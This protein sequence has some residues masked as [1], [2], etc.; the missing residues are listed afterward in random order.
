M[1]SMRIVCGTL[2]ALV[3]LASCDMFSFLQGPGGLD[4]TRWYTGSAGPEVDVTA[5][6]PGDLYLNTA[7]GDIFRFD[8]S[9]WILIMN[10]IGISGS[11]GAT[12]L[13]GNGAPAATAGSDGDLYLDVDS[14]DVF[15]RSA[16][17]WAILLNIEG[18]SGTAGANGVDGATWITGAGAPAAGLG[19][20]GDLYLDISTGDVFQKSA[21]S[22]GAIANITGPIGATGS[23]GTNGTDGSVWY[24]GSGIPGAGTGIDGDFYLDSTSGDIYQKSAGAWGA[25]IA[26]LTGPTGTAGT[27]GTIH[28][29]DLGALQSRALGSIINWGPDGGVAGGFTLA[30]LDLLIVSPIINPPPWAL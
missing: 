19:I 10:V 28:P 1:K 26:N 3:L 18:Q 30:P 17:A 29:T 25:S 16:G 4:G 21:G 7:T 23:A 24:T 9:A 11:D 13:S 2:A 22:W 6:V 12:W 15:R 5:S 27:N 14:G 20:D 8:G